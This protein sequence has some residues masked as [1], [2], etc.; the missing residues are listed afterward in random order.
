MSCIF[1]GFSSQEAANFGNFLSG[2]ATTLAL[3]FA[4]WAAKKELPKWRKQSLMQRQSEVA[5]RLSEAVIRL[6][7][8]LDYLASV[9]I[10][11]PE[12]PAEEAGP[13]KRTYRMRRDHANRLETVAKDL[14]KFTLL[15]NEAKVF[16]DDALNQKVEELWRLWVSTKVD[17]EMHLTLL[18]Q[19][20]T[21]EQPQFYENSYGKRGQ[22]KRA[23]LQ[24]E[25]IGLLRPIVRM[26]DI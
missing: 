25:L 8:A 26:D 15:S 14:E 20:A 5:G 9:K 3:G 6:F 4:V 16:L 10:D 7:Q 18:D 23:A 1:A 22:D 11:S 13:R 2:V 12:D 19:E 24:K 17:I 21:R